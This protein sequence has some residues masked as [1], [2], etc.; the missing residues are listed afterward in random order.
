[1]FHV[2]VHRQHDL[3][4]ERRLAAVDPVLLAFDHPDGDLRLGVAEPVLE[5]HVGLPQPGR[6][7]LIAGELSEQ[8]ADE[9]IDLLGVVEVRHLRPSRESARGRDCCAS[10]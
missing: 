4:L 8:P 6:E 5:D 7:I 1:M 9:A 10:V 3:R 2:G